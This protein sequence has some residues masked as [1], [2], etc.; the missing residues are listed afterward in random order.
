MSGDTHYVFIL[1]YR[2][3]RQKNRFKFKHPFCVGYYIVRFSNYNSPCYCSCLKC[4]GRRI[5][6]TIKIMSDTTVQDAV[7]PR[8]QWLAVHIQN[9]H[10]TARRETSILFQEASLGG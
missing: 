10:A 6:K 2:P 5:D 7:T 1:E 8:I 9:Q 3:Y 4:A